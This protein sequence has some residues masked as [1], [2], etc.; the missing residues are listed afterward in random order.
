MAVSI[1]ATLVQ[2]SGNGSS[3]VGYPTLFPF[4]DDAWVN[5]VVMDSAGSTTALE[6][7]S[8]FFLTGVGD[9]A[10]GTVT[11]SAAW[12]ATHTITIYRRVPQTQLLELEYN[13]R[14][15]AAAVEASLDK[16][17]FMVQELLAERPVRFPVV[18]P[19]ANDTEL[20]PPPLRKNSVLGFDNITGEA[21]LMRLP[22]PIVPISPPGAGVY[23]LGSVDGEM[24]WM[25]TVN[26][27]VSP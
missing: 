6:L 9:D 20:P 27:A 7:G 13:T 2:Y 24:A 18:E 15:P 21:V 26:C 17:V 11:T 8:T 25:A 16:Q 10:G 14:L 22:V 3:V 4:T 12:D 5:V 19:T 1:T 23:V